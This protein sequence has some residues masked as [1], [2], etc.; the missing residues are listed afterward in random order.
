MR[1]CFGSYL[2]VLVS[3]KAVNVDNKV[4][5]EA[6]LH[7]VAPNYE[8]VFAGQE[9]PDRVRED[10]SSKLLRCEQNLSK[11]V[12]TPA[13]NANPQ[14]VAASFKDKILPLLN[15]SQYRLII[16]ALKDIIAN[17][18]PVT[19]GRSVFGIT[20]DTMV[21]IVGGTIKRELASLSR[22]SVP[23][24][25][26]GVF[27][28]V[29]AKTNN[30]S[31]KKSI[32]TVND[33][34]ILSFTER[35]GEVELIDEEDAKKAALISAASQG[36]YDSEFAKDVASIVSERIN[37]LAPLAKAEK[38]LLV[39]LLT[40]ARGKCLSCGNKLGIPVRGKLPS[41]NCEIVYITFPDS[42]AH[43][44]ENAVA[45][46]SDKCA[47][48]V[49]LMSDEEKRDLLESKKR[50]AEIQTFL[51]KI[52]GIKFQKEIEAVLREIHKTKNVGGLEK[53]DIKDLVEIEQ[54]IHEPYLKDKI[55]ACM[56]RLYKTVKRICGRLEQ[57]IGFDTQVFG[58]L[59]KSAQIVLSS[60]VAAKEDITD[61]QEYV[62]KLLVEKLSSQVGQRHED[63]CEIIVGYLVKRCDLFN[64]NAKQ[65]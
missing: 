3:C 18:P 62:V 28:F 25:L 19:E 24:F 52:Q 38:D 39:T 27:L 41:A 59:M 36:V 11:E 57:E 37:K 42:E 32:R 1:L 20:D 58:E 31:G 23:S 12:T 21:D 63:A 35:V 44:Y 17:D 34:Y 64:E 48:E 65:S 49:A 40:E 43:G 55:D 6:L 33:D 45:L 10:N 7:S 61:R 14:D 53:T 22:F 46:C 29:A 4:L 2:A 56:V 30:R 50:C 47:A 54:K 9:N 16:L 5:C 8:F 51:D 26:A 60:G 13:R 15:D